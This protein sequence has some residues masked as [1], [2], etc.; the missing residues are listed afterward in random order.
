[1]KDDKKFTSKLDLKEINKD[2]QNKGGTA[3]LQRLKKTWRIQGITNG[4]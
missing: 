1:M 2:Q 4:L 3:K